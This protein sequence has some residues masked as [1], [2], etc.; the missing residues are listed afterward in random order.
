MTPDDPLYEDG[1]P[2]P[3]CTCVRIDVDLDDASLC[4]A[5]GPDSE[6]ARWQRR[7][8][9][10]EESVYWSAFRGGVLDGNG[11]GEEI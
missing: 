11:T 10:D 3:E 2:E 7:R 1:E 5:H 6:L 9:A 4:L 8:E